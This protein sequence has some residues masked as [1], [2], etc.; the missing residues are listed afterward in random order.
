MTRVLLGTPRATE[1]R[2][3]AEVARSSGETL[4]TLLNDILDLYKIEA[5]QLDLDLDRL[6]CAGVSRNRWTCSPPGP[7][8]KG[9]I[10]L[11]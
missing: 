11:T 9:W 4:R 5:G 8:R 3:Y 6:T 10:W 7:P 1:Q 2:E